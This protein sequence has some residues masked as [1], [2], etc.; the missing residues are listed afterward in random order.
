MGMGYMPRGNQVSHPQD[1]S[2]LI[3]CRPDALSFSC[4]TGRGAILSLPISAQ[5][6]DTV[7]MG[8]FAKYIV[9]HID[10]WFVFARERGAG[11]SR[12]EDIVLVTGCDLARSWAN[13]AFQEGDR[14]VSFKAQ[15]LGDSHVQWEFTP[16]GARGVG[17][18]VGPRGQVHS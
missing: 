16:E 5:R 14:D 12:R 15:V 8:E 18:N 9:R 3:L 10:E 11:I 6:V 1:S 4:P 13:V 2:S 17:Y 7:A